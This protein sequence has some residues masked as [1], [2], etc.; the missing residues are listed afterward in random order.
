[1]RQSF[2][3]L[4]GLLLVFAALLARRLPA[5]ASASA[6]AFEATP[7]VNAY[8]PIILRPAPVVT[9][10][11]V[12]N[13]GLC[14]VGGVIGGVAPITAAFTASSAITDV[15]QMRVLT[16]GYYAPDCLAESALAQA[17]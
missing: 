3:G 2:L 8:L 16:T 9:G 17:A 4:A 14:C 6:P 1:V 10:S 11:V 15:T 7:P 5:P 12:L 13:G